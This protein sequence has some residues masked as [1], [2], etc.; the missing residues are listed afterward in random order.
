MK[1]ITLKV[2]QITLV[3]GVTDTIYLD[4]DA[5]SPFPEMN[6]PACAKIETASDAGYAWCQDVL[7]AKP[8]VITAIP[9]V[10]SFFSR[11]TI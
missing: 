1:E 8:D 10:S 2:T 3:Q 9:T 5:R 11:K 6:Y 4:L 7:G